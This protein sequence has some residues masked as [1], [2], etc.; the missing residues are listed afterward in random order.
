MDSRTIGIEEAA[1][2]LGVGV[3]AARA[4]AR[5]GAIPSIRCG[6]LLRVPVDAFERLLAG[7]PDVDA[8]SMAGEL[9]MMQLQTRLDELDAQRGVVAGRLDVLKS[10]AGERCFDTAS[11]TQHGRIDDRRLR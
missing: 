1:E 10:L 4:A 7:A 8:D 5:S 11:P 2:V 6:R 3:G 9:E